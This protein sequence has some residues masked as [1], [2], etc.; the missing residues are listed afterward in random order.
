MLIKKKEYKLKDLYFPTALQ[1]QKRKWGEYLMGNVALAWMQWWIEEGSSKDCQSV[2]LP[3]QLEIWEVHILGC[4]RE[5]KEYIKYSSLEECDLWLSMEEKERKNTGWLKFLA[6][7][8][9]QYNWWRKN[10]GFN[11]DGDKFLFIRLN[12]KCFGIS[13]WLQSALSREN[14]SE[15]T[16][17]ANGPYVYPHPQ[18]SISIKMEL[19]ICQNIRFKKH[20]VW[21]HLC[22]ATL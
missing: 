10:G 22:D 5:E 8:A 11:R 15:D 13:T 19:F 6:T 12:M 1:C 3:T 18:L 16:W 2:V 9:K 7:G 4:Y 21:G 14:I 20:S 17:V